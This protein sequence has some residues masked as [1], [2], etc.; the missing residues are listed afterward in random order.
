MEATHPGHFFVWSNTAN[1]YMTKILQMHL[2]IEGCRRQQSDSQLKLYKQFFSY[3]MGISLRYCNGREE[4]LE[5]TNDGFLKVFAK[6]DQ[7]K[8]DQPFLPWLRKIII[9]A[10]ID[11]HRKYH[12]FESP[13]PLLDITL[14]HES[15]GNEALDHLAFDDLIRIMQELP[16]VYRLVFNLYV[17]DGLTH[18]EIA[19]KLNISVGSSKSNLSKAREKIKFF[20][21]ESLDVHLKSRG[22]GG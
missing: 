17:V 7:Y 21:A 6:I 14:S 8:V 18:Q 16:P 11:Y 19:E 1:Q 12:K 13:L 10:S 20:L 15:V 5:V 22:H 9:N 4:A 3:A 2:L